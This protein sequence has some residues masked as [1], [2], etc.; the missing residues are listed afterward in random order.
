MIVLPFIFFH[1]SSF[2]SIQV[3]YSLDCTFFTTK[4]YGLVLSVYIGAV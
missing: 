1:M 2:L 3:L 4:R